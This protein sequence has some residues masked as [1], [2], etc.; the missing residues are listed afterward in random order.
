MAL[1]GR[2]SGRGAASR[3]RPGG[4]LL[5]LIASGAEG[6]A[7]RRVAGAVRDAAL[8]DAVDLGQ[9]PARGWAGTRYEGPG[10]GAALARA[11]YLLEV[12][13][14]RLPW[15]DVVGAAIDARTH[16][17]YT[18]CEVAG[19]TMHDALLTVRRITAAPRPAANS[20]V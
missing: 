9:N 20:P 10:H 16:P 17:G 2:R 18:A 6:V 5:L 12:L 11:G 19:A 7:A 4:A 14:Q 8:G 15:S 13:R 1:G 3:V